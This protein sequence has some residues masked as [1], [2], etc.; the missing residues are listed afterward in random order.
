MFR[1]IL[2]LLKST[3]MLAGC[4]WIVMKS[5]IK[6]LESKCLGLNRSSVTSKGTLGQSHSFSIS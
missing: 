5:R 4:P 2:C 3:D 6:T 1:H